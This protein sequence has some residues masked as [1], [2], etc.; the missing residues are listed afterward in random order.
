MV[1]YRSVNYLFCAIILLS[2]CTKDNEPEISEVPHIEFVSLYPTM[3]S[4]SEGPIYFTV[5]YTDGDG[6][7]G[8]NTTDVKNLF[9]KDLRNNIE[10][11]YRLQ[12]LAPEG[13]SIA[14]QGTF[15]I[16][17]NNT[18]ITDGSNQQTFSYEIRVI[19]RAGN[20]SNTIT[21]TPLTV[22]N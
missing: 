2:S 14:I 15:E 9:L 13:S 18:S 22:S 20:Q 8:E 17:L 3:I 11:E 6:D 5:S 21:S 4:Q 10:Y 16:E 12:Q 7:L 19:D 1:F